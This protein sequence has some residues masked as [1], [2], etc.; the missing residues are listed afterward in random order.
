MLELKDCKQI[1]EDTAKEVN[2]PGSEGDVNLSSGE[3]DLWR[4]RKVIIFRV[5]TSSTPVVARANDG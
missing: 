5:P 3:L 2:V 4:W 1:G